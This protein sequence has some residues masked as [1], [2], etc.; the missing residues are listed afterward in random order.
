MNLFIA[1]FWR[2]YFFQPLRN[3]NGRLAVTVPVTPPFYRA[4]TG[5]Q[6]TPA[7]KPAGVQ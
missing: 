2:I 5:A 1:T 7:I 4:V 6:R 3:V